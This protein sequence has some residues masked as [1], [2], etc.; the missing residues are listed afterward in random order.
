MGLEDVDNLG[1]QMANKVTCQTSIHPAV[2]A[3]LIGQANQHD[4]G[5]QWLQGLRGWSHLF[6]SSAIFTDL[7]TFTHT[8][9]TSP[10]PS[11]YLFFFILISL[12]CIH[13]VVFLQSHIICRFALL[14]CHSNRRGG[15]I[16]IFC[17]C[18]I[19]SN[20]FLA[21]AHLS[22][23]SDRRIEYSRETLRSLYDTRR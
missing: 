16:G 14:S 4:A 6:S 3:I 9:L 5:P 12:A 19:F 13:I 15:L 2:Y 20:V 22:W 18:L 7:H 21:T 11:R 8:Y 1:H 10:Q 17:V 23:N